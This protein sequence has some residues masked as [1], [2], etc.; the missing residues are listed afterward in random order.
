MTKSSMNN[1]ERSTNN[2]NDSKTRDE[3]NI[4]RTRNQ[5]KKQIEQNDKQR[6]A[7]RVQ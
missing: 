5:D 6:K 1:N 7:S 3:T 2:N 4:I